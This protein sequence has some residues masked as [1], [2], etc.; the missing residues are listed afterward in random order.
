MVNTTR[1]FKLEYTDSNEDVQTIA[2][3]G[4][5]TGELK[6]DRFV[7]F[8]RK[9]D[10][11]IL[12]VWL[13][14]DD[15]GN[16]IPTRKSEF[17]TASNGTDEP[18]IRLKQYNPDTSSF[19][20]INRFY[21]KN[22]GTINENGE[23]AL[24]LYSFFRFTGRQ[25]VATGTVSDTNGNGNVDIEDA[26]NATLPT[27]Y[28]AD[29]PGSV[30]PPTVTGYSLDA[31]REKGFHELTRD[32]K[33][34]MTFTGN[35]DGSNN[36][37]VKYE[38]EG[39]GGTVD[40][41]VSNE[42]A[43]AYTITAVDTTNEIFTVPG[44]VTNQL[45]VDQAILVNGSTGN[46]GTY[47][48]TNLNYDGGNNETDI[49]VSEDITSSTADGQIIPGGQAIFKSWEKDKTDA[50]INKVKVEGTKPSDSTEVVGTAENTAQIN[51]FGE[52]FLK[53]KRGY[54]E[55][56]SEAD[57]I[58][59]SYL[60]PGKD[61][62]GNDITT[63]PESGT[64]KTSVYSD[65]VV[66]DSFQVV[67][68]TRNIDDTYTVV[69][70][71]NYWPEGATE[72]EFEFEKENL[73]GAARESENLRDERARLYPES[74]QQENVGSQN[75]ETG[76]TRETP[77]DTAITR[78]P[79]GV[80][81][82]KIGQ[83]QDA[84]SGGDIVNVD[85]TL[86]DID[87]FSWTLGDGAF[88]RAFLVDIEDEDSDEDAGHMRV[89]IEQYI[90]GSSGAIVEWDDQWHFMAGGIDVRYEAPALSNISDIDG[91]IVVKAQWFPGPNAGSDKIV[92]IDVQAIAENEH[93]HDDDF[94]TSDAKH[95]TA[96]I[97]NIIAVDTAND[98]VTVSGDETS[99][100][101]SSNLRK[102][103]IRIAGSTGNDGSYT[104]SNVTLN[105]SG[106]TEITVNEDLTDSTADGVVIP[107]ENHGLSGETLDKLV[108]II[109]SQEEKT[110]R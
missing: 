26:L 22:K 33:W 89:R 39:F 27:G 8:K 53:V 25:S 67:D 32:F 54:I 14:G 48:I 55:T 24:K 59:E 38:P 88:F 42:Q 43:G 84:G 71:R 37:L 105:G 81:S 52:K 99:D 87:T 41:L 40:T 19:D 4:Q 9:N 6:I 56:E 23:L 29:V 95:S 31:R 50:I 58:A 92:D 64:V 109:T 45:V 103:E 72:L 17:G 44:N 91:D 47:T 85:A 73:E 63:V 3:L 16:T 2:E 15:F 34:A 20:L 96:T 61:D 68:N 100:Y 75:L 101:S 60:V 82:N 104:V 1:R 93:E 30:T 57:T 80:I 12:K 35:L 65:N 51:N 7:E 98:I 79:D 107:E 36:A 62:Q 11:D 21:A 97:D 110:D 102:D 10:P 5:D 74:T 106:N 69:E 70:Q 78:N 13:E 49:T 90:S 77:S 83:G 86:N 94:G 18:E 46:D 28:A 108:D 76:G 66:N